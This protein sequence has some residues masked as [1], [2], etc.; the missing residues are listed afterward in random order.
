M[1]DRAAADS[2][3]RRYRWGR[4]FV[5]SA[6]ILAMVVA[7]LG[8]VGAALEG[9]LLRR[10]MEAARHRSSVELMGD[11]EALETG[12]RRAG[13]A[14]V[15]LAGAGSAPPA[16]PAQAFPRAIRS[17]RDLEV[18]RAALGERERYV[19]ELKA[20]LLAGF[21]EAVD[22][23]VASLTRKADKIRLQM[24]VEHS[25]EAA[26]LEARIEALRRQIEEGGGGLYR[27][28]D[29]VDHQR[30]TDV[31]D[32][33]VSFMDYLVTLG[34]G[35]A[36]NERIATA[37][38]ALGR[39]RAGLP[40]PT[41]E[42]QRLRLVQDLAVVRRSLADLVKEGHKLQGEELAE[43]LRVL[44]LEVVS[45]A[46]SSWAVDDDLKRLRER[47]EVEAEALT[48]VERERGGLLR[49]GLLRAGAVLLAA[50]VA[51]VLLM[52]VADVFSALFDTAEALARSPLGQGTPAAPAR[53]GEP[54]TAAPA[55]TPAER[56]PPSG[57]TGRRRRYLDP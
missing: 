49:R 37:R 25:D 22:W 14:V 9:F 3:E 53:A 34:G 15:S 35:D 11:V 41:S 31:L 43:R 33:A 17:L 2:P 19:A 23:L 10:A 42:G 44:C 38:Q 8:A 28:M 1:S 54:S 26:R 55:G 13:E 57:P 4:L 18:A 56:P 50:A 30:R 21:P 27:S 47:L 32:Q 48:A 51:S 7:A 29:Q 36:V 24:Q 45:A 20:S 39:L 40:E 6:T 46:E 52:L 16:A 5:R 12:C